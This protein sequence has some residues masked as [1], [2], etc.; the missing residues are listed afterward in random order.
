MNEATTSLSIISTK[1]H[2]KELVLGM[3]FYYGVMKQYC[4]CQQ[5]LAEAL[6]L[7][8]LLFNRLNCDKCETLQFYVVFLHCPFGDE[9]K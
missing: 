1:M 9:E 3:L 4:K 6:C 2:C 8:I 5:Q 7:I